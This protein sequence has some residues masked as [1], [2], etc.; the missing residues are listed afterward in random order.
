MHAK[1]PLSGKKHRSKI[2]KTMIEKQ[3]KTKKEFKYSIYIRYTSDSY[4]LFP[5][6]NTKVII[7]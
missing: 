3:K 6:T 5:G 2:K 4:Q 7:L 1:K